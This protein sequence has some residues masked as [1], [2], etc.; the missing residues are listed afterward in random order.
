MPK[1]LLSGLPPA[2]LR[3]RRVVVRADLNV[4]LTD[5]GEVSDRTRI[6]ASLPTLRHLVDAGARVVV[7]S[8]LGR[9]QGSPDPRFSLA[10]V[11]R[12]LGEELGS[13]VRFVDE[14]VGD[15]AAAAVRALGEGEVLL[16]EN[17]RFLPGETANAPELAADLAAFGDLFVNDAF[18]TAHRAHASTAGLA[19]AVRKRG[20]SAVAGLLLERELRF[21]GDALADPERPFVAILG[22]AKIS[23]KI[24][25]VEAL[26]PRVDRLIVGGAMANTFFLALGLE[27]GDSLVEPDRIRMA[28]DLLER[29]GDRLLLPVDV[30]VAE[31]IEADAEVRVRARAAVEPGDRIIDIGPESEALFTEELRGARTVVWNGPMGVFE[32]EPFRGGTV[33]LAEAA[34]RAADAGATVIVGG[35]DSAAAAEIAGVADRLTH[36]STGGGASLELLAGATLPAI[37]A[38][39]ER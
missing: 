17:T 35:G 21:L 28:R 2:T 1:V 36:I 16:L 23:G 25:V 8:H 11:A 30:R 31:R 13:S 10:P 19:D 18:G 6:R 29:A 26:L 12:A 3:G 32:L 34:A 4:P 20:G 5:D 15:E 22:G 38:L 24:D 9:P 14:V 37:E 39:D 27:V 33:R 7:L